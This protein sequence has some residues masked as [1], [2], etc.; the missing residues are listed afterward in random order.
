MLEPDAMEGRGDS[1]RITA[2]GDRLRTLVEA[3]IALSSELSL[4]AL[5]QRI[6]DTAAE[7]T[8]ARYAA[9]GVVDRAGQGLERF[10][11][12]GI[13]TEA[14]AAIGELPRGRGI[15][16]VLI[17]D[18]RP[19]RLRD[20]AADPRSVGFP[21]NHPP[22]RTFL[23]VPIVLRGVAFGN[24]YLTEKSGGAEFTSEDEELTMRIYA[25][26]RVPMGGKLV[27]HGASATLDVHLADADYT[28][29]FKVV[30]YGGT[31][32]GAAVSEIT[33]VDLTGGAWQ[34]ITIPL[35]ATGDHFFY[36]EVAEPSPDRMA[37]SAPI[38]ITKI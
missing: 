30:V 20:I 8:D 3:G 35:P 26:K 38:W 6:V 16:G 21:V 9:L 13:D 1:R 29:T 37:W 14:H 10:F 33:R 28:G 22:M 32:G 12:T 2:P 25:D 18:A 7:L 24:L 15:L 36:L 27:T 4:D 19:L 34:Q 23:G 5:L 17:R 31:I 11:T